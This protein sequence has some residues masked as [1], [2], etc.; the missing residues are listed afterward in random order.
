MTAM[1]MQNAQTPLDPIH[2]SVWPAMMEMARRAQA[3]AHQT[4]GNGAK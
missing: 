3:N 4:V 2:A 1:P